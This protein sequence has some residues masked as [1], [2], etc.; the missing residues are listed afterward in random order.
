MY[1]DTS[2]ALTHSCLWMEEPSV[3][4]AVWMPW[5]LEQVLLRVLGSGAIEEDRTV[6]VS[7]TM[8]VFHM[9]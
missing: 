9:V 5:G 1:A 7:L 8:V 6:V 2:P 4:V 3:L